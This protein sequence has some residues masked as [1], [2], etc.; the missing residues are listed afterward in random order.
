MENIDETVM[1]DRDELLEAMRSTAGLKAYHRLSDE[2]KE[3][4]NML[5]LAINRGKSPADA[6]RAIT[7]LDVEDK[8]TVGANYFSPQGFYMLNSDDQLAIEVYLA[9]IT[10]VAEF[11][12]YEG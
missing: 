6:Y 7:A 12:D 2:G 3:V 11:R 4:F 8:D 10:L 1:L 5:G 9:R